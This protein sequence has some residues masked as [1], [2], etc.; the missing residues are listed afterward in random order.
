MECWLAHVKKSSPSFPPCVL[1]SHL[2][3]FQRKRE[4][5]VVIWAHS[6]C[7]P[8]TELTAAIHSLHWATGLCAR[9]WCLIDMV[10]GIMPRWFSWLKDPHQL[11]IMFHCFSFPTVC[12]CVCVCV[13]F[14]CKLEFITW[15]PWPQNRQTLLRTFTY[16][17]NCLKA[18]GVYTC[19]FCINGQVPISIRSGV[20]YLCFPSTP[21]D[22]EMT[23]GVGGKRG[24]VVWW[25][26][27]K[28]FPI[29]VEKGTTIGG[30]PLKV[31][32][33]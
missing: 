23:S 32:E 22:F 2:S 18:L 14:L 4:E 8:S 26:C 29:V 21:D 24:G 11:Y 12:V 31:K 19:F 33:P 1:P 20:L 13:L 28:R 30:S 9:G 25:P 15:Q 5:F 17:S 16:S 3:H 7:F 6:Q 10:Q 27:Q